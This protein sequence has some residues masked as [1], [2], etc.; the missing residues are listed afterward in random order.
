MSRN[1]NFDIAFDRL[2]GHEGGYVNDP[3]DPG[4]E[5]NWGI[6]KRSY[7]QLDIKS[8][9][10][11]AART[12]YMRDFWCVARGLPDSVLFQLFDFAVN[13]GI[14]TAIR[15]LQRAIGVA[16]DGHWGPHS[17]KVAGTFSESD[18]LMLLIAE[19]AEFFTKLKN[20]DSHGKGWIR[21]RIADNL[22]YA[23]SDNEV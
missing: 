5:T 7:P 21:K 13:S 9:T 4:G 12:I 18:M 15:A 20:W 1:I 3:N 19:R 11:D 8:L 22:R 14:S 10:R 6:S 16:D 17:L 2:I 23:A